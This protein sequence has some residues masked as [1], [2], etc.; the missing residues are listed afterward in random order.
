MTGSFKT[1]T[2][3]PTQRATAV[4]FGRLKVS[5]T[6]LSPEEKAFRE[7]L[8]AFKKS[9]SKHHHQADMLIAR[10]AELHVQHTKALREERE[11][12]QRNSIIT[13]KHQHDEYLRVLGLVADRAEYISAAEAEIAALKAENMCDACAGSGKPISG[14]PCMCG[15][16]G[17]MSGAAR[18][19]REQMLALKAEVDRLKAT[20]A[21][22][23]AQTDAFIAKKIICPWHEQDE[24]APGEPC[25]QCL[26][27]VQG[28]AQ[29]QAQRIKELEAA[30][31]SLC[32]E[33]QFLLKEQSR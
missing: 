32:Y 30:H 9:W 10:A 15:G 22:Y 8:E 27:C 12:A 1:P 11:E 31:E 18:Y 13:A 17:R 24:G 29:A 26:T 14:A 5:D 28:K 2:R 33:C 4:D 23:V 20:S 16:T 6:P 3:W 19:L 21:E 7:A 25:G